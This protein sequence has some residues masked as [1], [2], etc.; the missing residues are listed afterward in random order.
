MLFFMSGIFY[1]L[2]SID[3]SIRIYFSLNPAFVLIECYRDVLVHHQLPALGGMVY[4]SLISI[5]VLI[6]AIVILRRYDRIY[7]RLI[8]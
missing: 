8:Y 4:I 6:S 3:E 1:T 2:E 5:I 7:P